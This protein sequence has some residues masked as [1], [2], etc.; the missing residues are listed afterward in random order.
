LFNAP[1]DKTYEQVAYLAKK[2]QETTQRE[3]IT[4]IVLAQKN[5]ASIQ[6]G[7]NNYSAGVK[8]GGDPAQTAD[9]LLSN[10]YKQGENQS[11][12]TQLNIR[13]QLSRYGAGGANVD[14]DYTLHPPTGLMFDATWIG[15]LRL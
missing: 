12:D 15:K 9:Y 1:S 7:G 4:S 13:M 8:G 5:E 11:D 10:T 3:P 14:C 6:S 2:F